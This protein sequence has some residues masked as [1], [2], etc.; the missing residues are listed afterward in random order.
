MGHGGHAGAGQEAR[1]GLRTPE[2]VLCLL[3]SSVGAPGLRLHPIWTAS[4][5]Q[6]SQSRAVLACPSAAAQPIGSPGGTADAP[7]CAHSVTTSAPS[8]ARSFKNAWETQVPVLSAPPGSP[9]SGPH[10]LRAPPT[11]PLARRFPRLRAT[12]ARPHVTAGRAVSLTCEGGHSLLSGTPPPKL[13]RS[14]PG[15][16]IVFNI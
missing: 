10:L 6:P 1:V 16:S 4:H 15:P 8:V 14:P 13:S 2:S 9:V 5:T 12:G 7:R 11:G 3:R